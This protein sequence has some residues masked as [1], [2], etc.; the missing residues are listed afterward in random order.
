MAPC[1][2]IHIVLGYI[3]KY[4]SKAEKKTEPYEALAHNLFPYISHCA[5]FVSFVSHL[6][7]KLVSEQDWTA[8][9]VC[10]HLL[11][12]LLVKGS[13]IVLDVDCRPPGGRSRSAIINEEGIRETTCTYEKYTVYN[14][15]WAKSSYF[16]IFTHVNI[17]RILW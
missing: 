6:I 1:T 14:A 12:L 13:H 4:C 10:H 16:H 2:D 15:N 11:N 17:K 9:K 8:Q 5:L 7:N 3:V